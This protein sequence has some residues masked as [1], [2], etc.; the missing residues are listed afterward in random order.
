MIFTSNKKIHELQINSYF[1][2]N[3]ID[4]TGWTWETIVSCNKFLFS[5]CGK[6][7][8][9]WTENICQAT[10]FHPYSPNISLQKDTFS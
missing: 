7:I 4:I 1:M 5:N 8:V 6:Y 9:L 3:S 10:C 2:A